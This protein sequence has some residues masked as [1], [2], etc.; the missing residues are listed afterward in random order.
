MAVFAA[1]VAISAS[2]ASAESI[3]IKEGFVFVATTGS[4][5]GA[6]YF[7]IQNSGESADRLLSANSE[8]A[9]AVEFHSHLVGADGIARME[10]IIG[11]IEVPPGIPRIFE[12]GSDHLMLMGLTRSFAHDDKIKITLIFE[13]AGEIALDLPVKL[14][15]QPTKK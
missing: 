4:K 15:R 5:S 7:A 2:F 12:Q 6:A 13:H 8:D 3:A 1:T 10:K 11:S 9:R 14:G